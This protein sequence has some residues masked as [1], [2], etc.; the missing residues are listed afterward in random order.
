VLITE[1]SNT[2]DMIDVERYNVFP[3]PYVLIFPKEFKLAQE[4]GPH[5]ADSTLIRFSLR[6]SVGRQT[7]TQLGAAPAQIPQPDRI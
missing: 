4:L 5:L 3:E 1:E 7:E 6:S 2:S